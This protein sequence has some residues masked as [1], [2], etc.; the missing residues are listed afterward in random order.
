MSRNGLI[1]HT[2]RNLGFISGV[3]GA[4]E[5]EELFKVDF[6]LKFCIKEEILEV[7][8]QSGQ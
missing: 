1:F 2:L 8:I 4:I 3:M 5:G 6:Y 7:R